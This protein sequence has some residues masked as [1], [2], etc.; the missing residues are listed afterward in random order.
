MDFNLVLNR[1]KRLAQLDTS[2]FDEVRD[3]PR[4]TLPAVLI[5]V[6]GC[7][8]TGIGLLIWLLFEKPDGPVD[9][10]FVNWLLYI[11]ILGTIVTVIMWA[12]WVGVTAVML[13]SFFKEPV[14]MMALFRTM[15][16]AS[17]PFAAS[18]LMLLPYISLGIGIAALVGWFVLSIFAVQAASGADSGKV[19]KSTLAGF[20]VFAVILSIF[21]R[22]TGIATGA[23]LHSDSQTIE[24][25]E[26]YE[27]DVDGFELE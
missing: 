3:D 11:W 20:V 25:G 5:V 9:V 26:F 7:L 12:V 16:Y 15:G 8:L 4:E 19:I 2:P 17:F 24:E 13:Q 27:I 18:V 10:D 6:A 1:L 23:F 22:G 14:D 21:A